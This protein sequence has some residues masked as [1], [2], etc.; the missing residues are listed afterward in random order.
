[1]TKLLIEEIPIDKSSEDEFSNPL[2]KDAVHIKYIETADSFNVFMKIGLS[3]K[4]M[5]A[6]QKL[7]IYNMLEQY[8]KYLTE[9]TSEGET[10]Q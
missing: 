7:A 9:N 10:I 4:M 6:A 1:M 2:A 8:A 5:F 3:N